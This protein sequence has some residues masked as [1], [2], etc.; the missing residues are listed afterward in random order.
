M[1]ATHDDSTAPRRR[2]RLRRFKSD[3]RR[4]VDDEGLRRERLDDQVQIILD[5][6]DDCAVHEDRGLRNDLDSPE[7]QYLYRRDRLLVRDADVDRVDDVLRRFYADDGSDTV[8]ARIQVGADLEGTDEYVRTRNLRDRPRP[9]AGLTVYVLPPGADAEDAVDEVDNE[10]GVGVVTPDHVL[11]VTGGSGCCPA[12]EPEK[13]RLRRPDP[14]VNKD[15]AT[16]GRGVLVSVVDTGLSMDVVS[17]GRHSWLDGVRGDPEDHNP[18]DLR[19][20]EGHGTFISGI[21]RCM[22]PEAEVIVDGFLPHGGAVYESEIVRQLGEALSRVPDVVSLSAGAWTRREL[23]LLSFQVLWETRLRHLKGTVVVA[24]A[25]NDANRGP[26]WPAAFP[27][28]LSVG[29]L[30][31]NAQERA[32]YTNFGS[33]VDVY[34]RGSDIINAFPNGTYRYREAPHKGQYARFKNGFAKWSGTSFATPIVAGLI[35]A[36]MS[37]TGESAR[38]AADALK[39]RAKKNAKPGVGPILEPGMA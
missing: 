3:G 28:T 25:G 18:Q 17:S 33:W 21:V 23:P 27:W 38:D 9:I 35:A 22:A 1:S 11:Y 30:D 19:P 2:G 39:K 16:S 31:A 29:A 15:S 8:P 10:L 5:R 24:A 37:R 6:L 34:A 20:Y 32:Y 36:R 4:F 26:F 14:A 12:T 7:P 13:T